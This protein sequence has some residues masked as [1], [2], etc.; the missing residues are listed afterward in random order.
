MNEVAHARDRRADRMGTAAP[1]R[2]ISAAKPLQILE[3]GAKF[4][5]LSR[6]H[7]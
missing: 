5:L 7:D 1:D 3:E 2:L 6:F 4:A